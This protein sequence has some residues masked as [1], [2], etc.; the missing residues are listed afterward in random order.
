MHFAVPWSEYSEELPVVDSFEDLVAYVETHPDLYL[1]YSHGPARDMAAGAS[2]D[3]E[4]DVLLPGLSV[5]TISPEPWWPRPAAD[6]VAR[7]I[8]KYAELGEEEDRHA[9]SLSGTVVGSG[10]ITNRSEPGAAGGSAQ[11]R[12]ARASGAGVPGNGSTSVRIPE[13]TG[14]VPRARGERTVNE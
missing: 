14:G 13:V 3:Y 9:W 12:S 10:L 4:A 2:C 1:R 11:R 8:R 7:R 6:W 5:T